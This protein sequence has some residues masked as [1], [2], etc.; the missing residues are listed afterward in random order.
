MSR[1]RA[2]AD[3]RVVELEVDNSRLK[4]Q[5]HLL[6]ARSPESPL[7]R[8]PIGDNGL[9]DLDDESVLDSIEES[10]Q[11]FHGFLDLLRE[12]GLV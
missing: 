3:A 1:A 9:S 7:R 6:E 12:A 4:H 2:A 8:Q 5:V 11:K 10:F